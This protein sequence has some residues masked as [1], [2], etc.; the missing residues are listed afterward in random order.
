MLNNYFKITFR[1]LW[2]HR[3]FSFLNI[4]GLAIGMSAGF[5][6]LLLYVAFELSYDKFHTKGD[7]IY[8]VVADIKTPS[9]V[10]NINSVAWAVAPNLVKDFSE[11][12][13]AVRVDQLNFLVR[14][15][16][17]KFKEENSVS[18]DKDFFKVF[19]FKL[20]Q[21]EKENVLLEPYSLVLS[22][23]AARKY[24]G[25]R[26]PIG[27][28]LKIFD[29]G[30]NAKVMG[31][32]E[33]IPENSHIKADIVLSIT[34]FTQSLRKELD[35]QWM[36][37][38]ASTY[39]L[40]N[41]KTDIIQLQSKFPD[42]L[43]R[44]DG[45][46]MKKSKMFPTLLLE[47]LKDI[48]LRSARG[49]EVS[50]DINNVYIFSIIGIFI[51][52]IACINFINLMTA[53]SVERAKEVGIRK[54]IGA[55]KSQLK[56][57][58]I[59]ESILICL[60]AF[61][62]TV[63]L[64]AFFLPYFNDLAGKTVSGGIFSNPSMIVVLLLISLCIGIL[65]GIYPAFV[66]SSFKPINVLKGSF[67]TGSKGIL[68]RKGL[69]VTQFTISIALIMGTIIVYDQMNHM[70]NQDLGFDKDQT[71]ILET[72][73]SPAQTSLKLALNDLPGV[74]STSLGSAIP[75]GENNGAYSEIQNSNGDMQVANLDTYFVDYDYI[76]QFDLKVMAGRGF[77]RDF[78]TDST[79][80]MV[81]N[82][83]AVQLFGYSS[84]EEALGAKFDQWG[85]QGRIV[86]VVKDFHFKSLQQ[87]IK[88]LT[89]RIEPNNTDL[90]AVKISSENIQQTIASIGE[91]W[92]TILPD[93]PF[94]YYF[95]DEFFDRQYRSEERFGSLFLNFAV[96]A[97]LI[98]CLGL[99]G[100]AAYSTLQRKKEIGI[101]KV[102]GSSIFGIVHLFSKEFLKLVSI[103]FLIASPV[104]W[105]IMT[106]WLKDFAYRINI[107]WWMFAL[108]GAS[109]MLIAILTVS[110]HAIKASLTNP[111]KSLRTE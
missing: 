103:A 59:G 56:Y 79:E 69:V 80:A 48:Y 72:N 7:N 61:I 12:Q 47:P 54:V 50:G 76:P 96:L 23:T 46:N 10:L 64:I 77:S 67:S 110:F 68:L 38:G 26:N 25:D 75:G 52:L 58:F 45:E 97:I 30:F 91:N 102:T 20:I 13:S 8:R 74:K 4:V 73:V 82:E 19:D 6:I 86:G 35:E 109:A 104:A 107:Q 108:A 98:S 60:F 33:D 78:V 57:Q 71:L 14:K 88:P 18:A 39:V 105:L 111:V 101:R 94:D 42:F 31:V 100:L 66:L 93:K 53:R 29:E 44:H 55:G 9:E 90:I 21:R 36:N 51:L 28:T 22:E 43:E 40:L 99:L 3:G 11:I 81:L 62:I 70:R 17:L 63:V 92:Q 5:L 65:A 84:P 27:K 89:I 49:G 2:K 16:E 32:M 37:Y 87:D 85:R 95:L 106:Y 15:D 24:F 34:T 41:P 1:N 83:K